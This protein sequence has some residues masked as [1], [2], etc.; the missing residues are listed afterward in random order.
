[1]SQEKLKETSTTGRVEFQLLDSGVAVIR[2]GSSS[3]RVVTITAERMKSLAEALEQV[4]IQRPKGLIVTGPSPE[5]FTAGADINLIRDVTDPAVGE[6]M[7][8]Q[9][10]EVFALI[11]ALP[12]PSVAA[13]SGACVGGGCE[14]ALACTYRIISDHKN[15]LIGLPEIKLGILPG[16][17]G[18]Q[19]LPRLIGLPKA[20]DIILAGK[21]LRAKQALR[22]GLVS[23]VVPHEKLL[24]RAER[25][26][27]ADEAPPRPKMKFMDMLMTSNPIGRSIVKKKAAQGIQKETKGFY[28]APFAALES[29]CNGL[30]H[31]MEEGLKFEA[32]ELGRLIVTPESKSLVR[33]FFLTEGAKAIGKSAKK[34]VEH[35]H[36]VVIGA[37]VMGAGIATMLAR[38]DCGVILKDTT[39]AALQ[40]G[41]EHIKNSLGK[42]RYL[43]D[44]ERS[45][46]LNRIEATTKDSSNTGGANIAIEAI[47]EEMEAKKKVLGEVSR[48]MPP[49]AIVASNT[50]SLSVTE[51]AEAIENPQRVIGMHFFNP[52]EKMPLVEIVRAK[53][54][55]D[56]TIAVVAALASKLGKH[57]IVVADVPGFLVN[58]ILTPYLNEAAYLLDEGYPVELID[59][60]ATTFG[61][62]M[63][64][65][66][67]LD[68]VGLDVAVHVQDTMV[69]G[70]GDRMKSPTF[71]K[72][73]VDVKR[74]G[75]KSG[76]GFYDFKDKNATVH[77]ELRTLLRLDKPIPSSRDLKP[78]T[79]RLIL[80]LI[81]EAVLCLDEGVA[82]APG[83][84][85]ANQIDLGTV[86]GMGFPPFRGGL[87]HYAD[88]VGA[89]SIYDQLVKLEQT[90]GKRFTAAPG[91]KARAQNGK[92]FYQAA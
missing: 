82:G 18:T 23:E 72:M 31:G 66:R 69:K 77:P 85:A 88:S 33:I 37:G 89:K 92:H 63:G 52:V 51:I 50:S 42:L 12:C 62:P 48:V 86:M 13:I 44:Q 21:T 67:L 64:P 34:A 4:R 79:D 10:Q 24:F 55:S 47:F 73:L 11:S 45:F 75:R 20:L 87:M 61:M 32:K 6:K 53:K 35:V 9:G 76:A 41:L 16:F 90:H 5:M 14:L 7:A 29:A 83:V 39:D 46:I 59:K 57:P 56:K 78:L 30:A 54:T 36:A 2:L 27:I 19:R 25:M 80:S 68:E 84:D 38:S 74:F 28:P 40:R 49:E 8:R 3:E 91:I 26:L 65:I 58:R 60:A 22:Y 81:N 15:S 43:S 17:G 70:Y 71:A 1:M